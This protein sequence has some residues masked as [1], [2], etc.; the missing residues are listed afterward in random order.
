MNQLAKEVLHFSPEARV[1]EIVIDSAL[2]LRRTV[3]TAG[4]SRAWING[5]PATATQLRALGDRVL[6]IHGQHAWQRLTQPAATRALLDS[7]AG[8]DAR[9]L[10]QRFAGLLPPMTVDEALQSAAVASLAFFGA[11]FVVAE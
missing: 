11:M 5:S 4:K 8:I 9:L 1:V 7:Q 2:L 3:D 6:D 10:A